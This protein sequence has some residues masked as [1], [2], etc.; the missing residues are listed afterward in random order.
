MYKYDI[1]IIIIPYR[2]YYDYIMLLA[3]IINAIYNKK[4]VTYILYF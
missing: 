2:F 3:N 4:S 1:Y